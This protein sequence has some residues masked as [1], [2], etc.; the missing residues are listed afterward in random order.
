[1]RTLPRAS[2]AITRSSVDAPLAGGPTMAVCVDF[3]KVSVAP[4]TAT[5]TSSMWSAAAMPPLGSVERR[6]GRRTPN[7][8]S[9]ALLQRA[10]R[11]E[12]LELRAHAR[13]LRVAEDAAHVDE[14]HQLAL[15]E[16]AAGGV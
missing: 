7:L 5:E 3:A 10:I 4:A 16:A 8:L 13:P 11:F 15:E 6:H 2:P 14:H 1:M 12:A 9:P